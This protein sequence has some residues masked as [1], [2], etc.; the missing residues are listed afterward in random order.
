MRQRYCTRRVWTLYGF[1]YGWSGTT[2]GREV[3]G[4]N[5]ADTVVS[6]EEFEPE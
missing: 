3:L 6:L 1:L 2:S 4:W 5:K